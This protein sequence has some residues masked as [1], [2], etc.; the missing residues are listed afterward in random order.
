MTQQ[1]I[2]EDQRQEIVLVAIYLFSQLGRKEEVS[3][4]ELV[5]CLREVQKEFPLGYEFPRK[6][7]YVC[8]DLDNDL[9][10][11]WLHQGYI[12]R[13]RY[14]HR[15]IPLL[16]KHFVALW[17][18]GRRHAKKV[19]QTLDPEIIEALN[20]AVRTMVEKYK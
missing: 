8:F 18:L 4:S 11:L 6:L 3:R 10:D 15:D 17:P 1:K 12:R 13:Y 5:D 2:S 14:G 7:L 19:L 9:D 20:K 16:P